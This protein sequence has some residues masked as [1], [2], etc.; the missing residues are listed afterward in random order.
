MSTTVFGAHVGVALK[1]QLRPLLLL[2]MP[3][4]L[5]EEKK[6]TEGSDLSNLVPDGTV[7]GHFLNKKDYLSSGFFLKAIFGEIG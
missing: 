5:F 4:L 2:P 7:L 6:N 1:L 3:E